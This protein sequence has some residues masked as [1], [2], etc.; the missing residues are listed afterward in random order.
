MVDSSRAVE[1]AVVVVYDMAIDYKVIDEESIDRSIDFAVVVLLI[2][3][4]VCN[5]VFSS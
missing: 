4:V 1:A 3:K 2:R 5:V